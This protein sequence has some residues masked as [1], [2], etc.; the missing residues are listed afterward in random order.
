M[1]QEFH[2]LVVS[3]VVEETL[4]S[5]SFVLSIPHGLRDRF[6]YAAG[7][8]VTVEVPWEGFDVRRCY[9]LS[10]APGLDAAPQI[11]VKRVEDGRVSNW[12]IDRVKPGDRLRVSQ[13]EGRF[14]LGAASEPSLPLSL[15]AAG[16]GITPV[17]SLLK[18][19]LHTTDRPV[20]LLFANRDAESVMF[21]DTLSSL[22]AQFPERLRVAQH[23][24][25]AGGYLQAAT[26]DAF[27]AG[28]AHGDHYVCGPAAFMDVVEAALD[29]SQVPAERAHFERFVSP[30]DPDRQPASKPALDANQ[31][32]P[33]SFTVKLAGR[34]HSVPLLP[35]QTLLE[36]AQRA[37]LKAPSSCESGYCGS[38]MALRVRGDVRMH[39][40]EALTD[41]NIEQG[42]VLLCQSV[43][44]SSEALEVDCD[45]TSFRIEAA[46]APTHQ[47][48][49]R[50]AVAV[51]VTVFIAAAVWVL[52]SRG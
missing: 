42:R 27:V 46:G 18:T 14:V 13:P 21:A 50:R 26:V 1:S 44:A 32:S 35:G 28:Q 22:A 2:E 15:Y 38:C 16:S 41:R 48:G 29:R 20:S 30:L 23:L 34:R 3:E 40:R 5:R 52:R 17:L 49:L 45:A 47:L 25:A 24:D 11:T 51:F 36:A 7:Q 4:D 33:T 39:T 10:S 19:A 43:A 9:S 8:F 37:G 6:G 31:E 12:L